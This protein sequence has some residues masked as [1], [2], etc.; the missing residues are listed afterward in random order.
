MT[1]T[2][3]QWLD[4]AII[5]LYL[6]V[7]A[8][9]GFYWS[10]RQKNLEMFFLAGRGMG[11]IPVGLS[12]MACLNSGIDYIM[13]PSTTI[14]YGIVILIG[15]SSWFFLWHWVRKVTLPFYRRL[16]VYTAYEY[17][18]NRFDE[19]VRLLA[20]AIFLLWRIGWIATA[21]YVPC[22]A[23]HAVSGGALPIVP[24]IIVLGSVVILYTVL[25]GMKAVIWTDVIQFFV[26]FGG[27]AITLFIAISNVQ[28][29]I[30]EILR[31][32]GEAGKLSFAF[33]IPGFAEAGPL[34]KIVLFFK[35]DITW[36]GLFIAVIVGRLTVYT[37]DQVMVQ[38]FQTT[39]SLKDA[40]QA[41]IINAV[42]DAVWMIGLSVVGLA[43]FAYFKAQNIPMGEKPDEIFPSFMASH[44]PTG[45]IGLVVAAI[46]AASLGAI[47]SAINSCTSVVIVDF[48]EY[49]L[50]KLGKQADRN[51]DS[52]QVRISRIATLAIGIV[53]IIIS[54]NV[55]RLGDL[56]EI[57]NKVIQLF[58]GPLFAIYIM[59][60]FTEKA[61]SRGV[62]IGG[63]TG[64][65]T[66]AY[67]AFLSE[68]G[69][70]WP[71]VFGFTAALAIGYL[72]S[73]ILGEKH[74]EKCKLT[75]KNIMKLPEESA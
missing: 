64:A 9:V 70:V 75:F 17:L 22:L 62:L 29:G 11:W 66:S 68:I 27:L 48:R 34:Q 12:L 73:L 74:C 47:G 19:S 40:R 49:I 56:I 28:G 71:S 50:R 57:A 14:K 3:F 7:L 61:N 38:R 54:S 63:L 25:G 16:K 45:I 33:N 59:G 6:A 31:T 21:M 5:V 26:M 44:F 35:T 41:F 60:M 2:H 24:T 8:A 15:V 39:K 55:G 46:F 53:A 51:G 43:L 65:L 58:T 32:A 72:F 42:G 23:M 52:S 36:L 1:Q 20:A 69:F 13:G 67:V 18:E 4:V 30:G 10:N 37:S